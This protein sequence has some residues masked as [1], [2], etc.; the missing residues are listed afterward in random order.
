M[1]R[2]IG[3]S[4]LVIVCLFMTTGCLLR[5]AKTESESMPSTIGRG[6]EVK[7]ENTTVELNSKKLFHALSFQYPAAAQAM[8]VGDYFVADYMDGNDLVFRLG[9]YYF[10]G[11]TKEQAMADSSIPQVGTKTVNGVEWDYYSGKNANGE[12]TE[13]YVYQFNNDTYTITFIHTKDTSELEEVFLQ[14][15]YFTLA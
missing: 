6:V 12:Q 9:V 8:T 3:L 5:Y 11:K 10:E 14:N 4:L 7:V 13:N 2:K 1:K 15:S